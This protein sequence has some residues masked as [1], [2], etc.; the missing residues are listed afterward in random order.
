MPPQDLP[1]NARPTRC[2]SSDHEGIGRDSSYIAI[3][4]PFL[5]TRKLFIEICACYGSGTARL[6]PSTNGHG[7]REYADDGG[8][9]FLPLVIATEYRY[10]MQMGGGAGEKPWGNCQ[11]W[12]YAEVSAGGGWQPSFYSF[13]TV[14]TPLNRDMTPDP[15]L[16]ALLFPFSLFLHPC[17]HPLSRAP[18]GVAGL[19]RFFTIWLRLSSVLIGRIHSQIPSSTEQR[20]SQARHKRQHKAIR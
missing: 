15:A 14:D 5:F 20:Y 10:Q 4:L 16:S 6:A 19:I 9:R 3:F 12:P 13:Y 11:A 7:L 2:P 18:S 17:I 1:C 8:N